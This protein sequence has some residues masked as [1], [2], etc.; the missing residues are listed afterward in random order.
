MILRTVKAVPEYGK[1]KQR[2]STVGGEGGGGAPSPQAANDDE[3]ANKVHDLVKEKSSSSLNRK[4]NSFFR[5]RASTF[6]SQG[7]GTPPAV[8]G[9]MKLK[10]TGD[11]R[12]EILGDMTVMNAEELR[13]LNNI[14]RAELRTPTGLRSKKLGPL[15]FGSDDDSMRECPISEDHELVDINQGRPSSGISLEPR[16]YSARYLGRSGSPRFSQNAVGPLNRLRPGSE[17]SGER[18]PGVKIPAVEFFGPGS[19]TPPSTCADQI[20]SSST[21]SSR[22]SPSP[23]ASPKQEKKPKQKSKNGEMPEWMINFVETNNLIVG[24]D[25]KLDE[26]KTTGRRR[27]SITNSGTGTSKTGTRTGTGTGTKTSASGSSRATGGTTGTK[28]RASPGVA[29]RGG[30]SSAGSRSPG[31]RPVTPGKAVNRKSVPQ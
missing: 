10:K 13:E 18:S 22:L 29:K 25:V 26:S 16:P 12:R 24:K 9:R 28:S 1:R 4:E 8:R 7:P 2:R 23:Q 27:S 15:R 14:M 21:G 6:G 30:T 17:S 5:E 20:T 3:N 19:P 31:G 11:W